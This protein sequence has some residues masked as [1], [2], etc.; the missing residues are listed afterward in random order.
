MFSIDVLDNDY[1][2]KDFPDKLSYISQKFL[3]KSSNDSG[4]E[5]EINNVYDKLLILIESLD[6]LA[7]CKHD[8]S[9]FLNYLP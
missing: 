8:L 9:C 1:R 7:E 2:S 4:N 6:R 5:I 3:T